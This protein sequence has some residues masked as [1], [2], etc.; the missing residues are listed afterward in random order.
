MWVSF[1]DLLS[2]VIAS[3][4]KSVLINFK[5][6]FLLFLLL[7]KSDVVDFYQNAQ[8]SCNRQRISGLDRNQFQECKEANGNFFFLG[9]AVREMI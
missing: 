3:L 7:K 6:K 4:L 5:K 2:N 1:N 8:F 9:I